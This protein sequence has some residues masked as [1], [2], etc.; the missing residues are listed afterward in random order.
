M[1][2]SRMFERSSVEVFLHSRMNGGVVESVIHHST[3][4]QNVAG[5]GKNMCSADLLKNILSKG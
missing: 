1:F 4:L 5:S 3:S 2:W